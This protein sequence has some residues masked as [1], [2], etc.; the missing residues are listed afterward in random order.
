MGTKR[1]RRAAA[2]GRIEYTTHAFEEMD[3]DDLTISDVRSVLLHGRLVARLRGDVRGERLLVRGS[4]AGD[5]SEVEVICRFPGSG[6]LSIITVY[7]L[8]D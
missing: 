7:R 4:L 2:Q 8:E 3:K 5:A 1:I 6:K